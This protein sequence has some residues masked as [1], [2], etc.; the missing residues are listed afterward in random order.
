M[1]VLWPFE[2]PILPGPSSFS[3]YNHFL[4]TITQFHY[5]LNCPQSSNFNVFFSAST[6]RT[7]G[8]KLVFCCY[9]VPFVSHAAVILWAFSFFC[10]L[11]VPTFV[12]VAVVLICPFFVLGVFPPFFCLFGCLW[13]IETS[14][15]YF[16]RHWYC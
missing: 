7:C 4:Q 15:W 12:F 2:C 5:N 11:L 14:T 13:V 6:S 1:A 8:S 16:E 10:C 9:P 3:T